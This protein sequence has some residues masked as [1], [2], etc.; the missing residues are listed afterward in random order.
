LLASVQLPFSQPE[1]LQSLAAQRFS[2]GKLSAVQV[3]DVFSITIYF[4]NHCN[5]AILIFTK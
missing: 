5:L 4:S 1:P 3:Q 2:G